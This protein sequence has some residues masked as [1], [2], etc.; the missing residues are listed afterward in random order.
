MLSKYI[1]YAAFSTHRVNTLYPFNAYKANEGTTLN[2]LL[3]VLL[4]SAIS[5]LAIAPVHSVCKVYKSYHTGSVIP[6]GINTMSW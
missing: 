6:P 1:L 4:G 5:P 3:Q 2:S